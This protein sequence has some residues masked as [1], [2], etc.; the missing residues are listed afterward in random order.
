MVASASFE[1]R[2][3]LE[4]AVYHLGRTMYELEQ[5]PGLIYRMNEPR[6][7]IL[8]FA[9]GKLASFSY[10]LIKTL[11]ERARALNSLNFVTT[12]FISLTRCVGHGY[13]VKFNH[14]LVTH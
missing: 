10:P 5:F 9:S 6:I 7:V 14:A 8:V 12:V 2:I 13:V 4:K 3:D 11:Y 1:V